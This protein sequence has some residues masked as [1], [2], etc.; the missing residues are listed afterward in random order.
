M[1]EARHINVIRCPGCKAR[2]FDANLSIGSVIEI[3]C[4]CNKK[5]IIIAT[6]IGLLVVM[7]E[8]VI[9]NRAP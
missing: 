3:K 9:Y 2:V 8:N 5:Y 6:T 4:A 1:S 7:S